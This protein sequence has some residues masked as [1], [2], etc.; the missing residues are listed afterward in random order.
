MAGMLNLVGL[1]SALL[2]SACS[3]VGVRSGTETPPYEVAARVGDVE[4]RHYP[5]RLAAETEVEGDAVGAR[6]AGFRR[7]A[8]FIFGGNRSRTDIAMTAPVGQSVSRRIAMT[9]PVATQPAADGKWVVRFFMPAAYTAETLPKPDDPAVTIVV[10]PAETMAVY[11]YTGSIA[12]DAV[13]QARRVLLRRLDGSD[14]RAMGEPV[15]WFYDPPWTLPPLRRNEVAVPVA[16]P[17]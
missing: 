2:S 6:S 7:L 8:G 1:G 5:A 12:A 17:P 13:A 14:W 3:V 16:P 4:I 11:R 10:V 9:A 15:D